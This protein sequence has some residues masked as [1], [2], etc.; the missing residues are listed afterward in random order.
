MKVQNKAGRRARKPRILK[1]MARHTF[2]PVM[3]PPQTL[4]KKNEA[5]K[6]N[7]FRKFESLRIRKL[8]WYQELTLVAEESLPTDSALILIFAQQPRA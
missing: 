3:R 1:T 5:F 2:P 8:L 7:E 4:R 6:K